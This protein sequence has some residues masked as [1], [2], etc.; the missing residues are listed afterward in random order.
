M[1]RAA[2]FI[3]VDRYEDEQLRSLSCAESDAHELHG[4]FKHRADFDHAECLLAPTSEQVLEAIE[5]LLQPLAP[6]DLFLLFFAGHGV[7]HEGQHLLLCA[8]ARHSRLRHKQ[9]VLPVDLLK[10]ETARPGL[11]RVFVLDACRTDLLRTRE[12]VPTGLVGAHALRDVVA[13]AGVPTT[14][15]SLSILCS[16]DEGGLAGEIASRR[17]GVFRLAFQ[18]VLTADADAGQPVILGDRFVADVE[19]RMKCMAEEID[20]AIPQ[21]PWLVRCGN[22]PP[23]LPISQRDAEALSSAAAKQSDRQRASA[24]VSPSAQGRK[25]VQQVQNTTY[26][27]SESKLRTRLA[28]YVRQ[29]SGVSSN[30]EW[31]RTLTILHDEGLTAG[32]KT[33]EIENLLDEER[34]TWIKA[35]AQRKEAEARIA[36]KRRKADEEIERQRKESE[37]IQANADEDALWQRC[38][39]VGTRMAL[40]EYTRRTKLNHY[41]DE[42]RKKLSALE[43]AQEWEAIR[44]TGTRSQL[45]N[46]LAAYPDTPQ[47]EFARVRLKKL[48]LQEAFERDQSDAREKAQAHLLL[49]PPTVNTP[50]CAEAFGE[51]LRDARDPIPSSSNDTQG[52][53]ARAPRAQLVGNPENSDVQSRYLTSRTHNELQGAET[54]SISKKDRSVLRCLGWSCA[55]LLFVGSVYVLQNARQNIGVHMSPPVRQTG[56]PKRAGCCAKAAMQAETCPHLCC[57]EAAKKQKNC[58]K[59]GGAN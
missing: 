11:H 24:S 17:G 16:C 30:D 41:A 2:L 5:R 33:S 12:G 52:S 51:L 55:F 45:E 25:Q 53:D 18:A 28:R 37:R 27:S 35:E 34:S 39:S 50:E 9:Q 36:E 47:A 54:G 19:N 3:G 8:K 29:W 15:G 40:L 57:S 59:C 43:V 44:D 4:F 38:S 13:G 26:R 23:L 1:K 32:W 6:E 31:L 48:I 58:E 46:F 49:K 20:L 22:P 56:A 14:G 42:V 7:T 21:R 10:E